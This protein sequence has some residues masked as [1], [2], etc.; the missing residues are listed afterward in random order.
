M[1][2]IL[3]CDLIVNSRR[4]FSNKMIVY[5]II[6]FFAFLIYFAISKNCFD[7]SVDVFIV[8]RNFSRSCCFINLFFRL[9]VCMYVCHSLNMRHAYFKRRIF[10]IIS[11]HF[12]NHFSF[13]LSWKKYK[14]S[15]IS[16]FL[17]KFEATSLCN[18]WYNDVLLMRSIKILT[19]I[20][21]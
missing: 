6:T 1:I 11:M 4:F 8:I 12:R 7:E 21:E 16:L 10:L 15:I 13:I 18:Y 9:Y 17:R 2:L 3:F 5:D 20:V 19:N 14:M